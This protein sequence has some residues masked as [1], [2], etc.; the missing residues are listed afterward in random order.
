MKMPRG[1]GG[2]MFG[3]RR[4]GFGWWWFGIFGVFLLLFR[5]AFLLL[6]F[7]LIGA[8]IYLIAKK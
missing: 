2:P 8:L 5:L 1:F 3:R 7:I 4:W 6:P